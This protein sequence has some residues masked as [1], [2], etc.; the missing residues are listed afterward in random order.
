MLISNATAFIMFVYEGTLI[1][2]LVVFF[3]VS[4]CMEFQGQALKIELY[5]DIVLNWSTEMLIFFSTWASQNPLFI[6]TEKICQLIPPGT[7]MVL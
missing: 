2:D 4:V 3:N 6:W 5:L 1:F 7:L